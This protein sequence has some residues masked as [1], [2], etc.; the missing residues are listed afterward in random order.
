MYVS[1]VTRHLTNQ[2]SNVINGFIDAISVI[3]KDATACFAEFGKREDHF[4]DCENRK[5]DIELKKNND[6]NHIYSKSS[7]ILSCI[8]DCRKYWVAIC[9]SLIVIAFSL[10]EPN[11]A[12]VAPTVIC[13]SVNE[14]SPPNQVSQMPLQEQEQLGQAK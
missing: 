12:E 5:K 9:N 10:E 6:V 2:L 7:N 8:Q 14:A 1:N 13:E 11:S 3:A 4:Q